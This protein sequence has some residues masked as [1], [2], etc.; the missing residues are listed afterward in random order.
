[1]VLEPI[2]LPLGAEL[3]D[4]V[5]VPA[6]GHLPAT[7]LR[8]GE[9]MR[10]VDVEG[11]QVADVILAPVDEPRDWLSCMFTKLLNGSQRITT[12]AVLYSKTALPL[13]RIVADTVGEHWFGGGFCSQETNVFRYGVPGA[14][15]CRDNLATSLQA[16]VESA[17]DLELDSC[18]S[19]FMRIDVADDGQLAIA[20]PRG[21]AGDYL[22]LQAD[23]DLLVALSACPADRNPCNAFDPTPLRV[24]RYAPA[25]RC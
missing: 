24:L 19:L 4:D 15:T 17:A 13:A 1:M 12:G 10:I 7:T 16:Y 5:L 6:R 9:C 8:C 2:Q 20:E 21:L 14:A 25:Q 23:Q 11:R 18:A 3:I 22:D